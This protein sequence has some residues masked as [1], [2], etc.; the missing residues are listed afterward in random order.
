MRSASQLPP[1]AES[2]RG[3]VDLPRAVKVTRVAIYIADWRLRSKVRSAL[4]QERVILFIALLYIV[5]RKHKG[6]STV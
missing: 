4:D 3:L 5:P 2:W 6:Y 1:Q